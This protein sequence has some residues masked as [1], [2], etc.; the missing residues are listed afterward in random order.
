M[1][2]LK[3]NSQNTFCTN[4]IFSTLTKNSMQFIRSFL[5]RICLLLFF[6][7]DGLFAQ[8]V[9]FSDSLICP[10]DT[11]LVTIELEDALLGYFKYSFEQD[12]SELAIIMGKR[13]FKVH[14][15]GIYTFT[16]FG[17]LDPVTYETLLII[18]TLITRNLQFYNLP[19]AW[20]TGGGTYCRN[21][22]IVPLMLNFRGEASWQLTYLLN[23]EQLIIQDFE[24]D[25]YEIAKDS[26]MLVE[27]ISVT[28][29][30]CSVNKSG[31]GF[32]LIHEI[33]E[34]N[35]SGD[36]LFCLNDEAVFQASANLPSSYLWSEPDAASIV[37]DNDS[38]DASIT[39]KWMQ[40]GTHKLSLTLQDSLHACNSDPVEMNILVYDLPLVKNNYDTLICFPP[41]QSAY[42]QPSA[43]SENN[44][45]WPETNFTG[46]SLA[47]T[48][49]G[50]YRYIE[51]TPFG[52][53]NEGEI[54]ALAECKAVLHVP[55]A[56]TPNNDGIN[57]E[58]LLFGQYFNLKLRIYTATGELIQ[59][60]YGSDPW[61]G[62]LHDAPAPTGIYY[63]NAEFTDELG[64][65]YSAK[66]QF[67]LLR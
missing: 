32:L 28:D 27:L 1:I 66:G 14:E 24:T 12:T 53:S 61:N 50:I 30:N 3:K 51:T 8:K 44:L 22:D 37:Q 48:E 7:P 62:M 59:E 23:N 10:K 52:C 16:E 4:V 64:T 55:E 2:L 17:I 9:T 35:L 20:L 29:A 41:G 46:F 39:L 33:P 36:S 19:N 45:F 63:W 34:A 40:A 15:P 6:I 13:S 43:V 65:T 49:P 11:A 67:T 42:L 57:D 54:R 47:I 58:L 31:T 5:F 60:H 38:F 26:S 21:E 25:Q 56:F 18:D